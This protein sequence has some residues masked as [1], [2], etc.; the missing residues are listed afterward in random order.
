[1]SPLKTSLFAVK[2]P[3]CP[4]SIFA[5]ENR[6]KVSQEFFYAIRTYKSRYKKA[7][8]RILEKL[9]RFRFFQR[10]PTRH[11]TVILKVDNLI[12]IFGKVIMKGYQKS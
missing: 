1:M 5:N 10:P 7:L 4:L 3:N 9:P 8:T 2:N 12:P 6:S 11:A